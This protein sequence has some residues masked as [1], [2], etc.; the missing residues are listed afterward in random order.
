MPVTIKPNSIS[1]R[2]RSIEFNWSLSSRIWSSIFAGGGLGF[3][4]LP[5]SL[6]NAHNNS[7]AAIVVNITF[8]NLRISIMRQARQ[9]TSHATS[10]SSID[11]FEALANPAPD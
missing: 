2:R 1:V 3:S 11:L 5:V 4:S 8:H 10:P 7:A 9:N 6:G